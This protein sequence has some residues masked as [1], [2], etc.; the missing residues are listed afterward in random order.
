MTNLI[1]LQIKNTQAVNGFVWIVGAGPGDAELLTIKAYNALQTA[2]VVLYDNLVDE[3]VL[4]LIPS[5]TTS[6]Y[7]GKR[8]MQHSMHQDDICKRIV[9]HAKQG[10]SVVRLKGGDPAVFARTAEETDMLT[11]QQIDFVIVPGITTASGASAY[12]GIPLTHRECAQSVIFT[13]ASFKS[14]EQE[15]NWVNLA[16]AAPKQTLVFYMGLK[17]I[18][19]IAQR[20]MENGLSA[21]YPIALIDKACTRE[22]KVVKASLKDIAKAV[23]NAKLSGPAIIICGEVVNYQQGVSSWAQFTS[24]QA[25]NTQ[26]APVQFQRQHVAV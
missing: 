6:E 15:P 18:A 10:K 14:P 24:S 23:E 26:T 4:Q 8:S 21:E 11:K 17:K 3:S 5:S 12:S 13:T 2:D 9:F 16:N 25:Q 20:L 22:Q 7:V 19:L 1:N